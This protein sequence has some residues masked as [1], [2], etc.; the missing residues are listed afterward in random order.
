[1]AEV[2]RI[3][4]RR[5]TVTLKQIADRVG[6]SSATVSRVLN[7]DNTLSVGE[8]TRQTIIET[9]EAMNYAPPRRR[10]KSAE[11]K[12]RVALLHFLRPQEELVDP[13]YVA[14]RLGIEAR[15]AALHQEP[16]KLYQTDELPEASVLKGV[17]GL[18]AIGFHSQEMI[19]WILRHNRNVVFAD[20]RP[21]DD[22][23]DCVDSDLE[24]A[25]VKLLDALDGLGYRRIA[26]AGWNSR[27]VPGAGEPAEFRVRAYERWMRAR[28]RFDPRLMETGN[29]TEESGHRLAQRLLALDDRPDLIVTGNDNMAVGAYRAIGSAGLRIPDDIAVAS[30]NDISTARFMSPPLTTVRLP[31]EAIGETAVDL[32]M[33]RI[34]GRRDLG[35]Q[36]RLETKIVWRRSTRKPGADSSQSRD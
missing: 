30:F 6:V 20:F 29:N 14:L 27:H 5:P 28:G 18:I 3:P 22:S 19:D 33:E 10:R 13:Y 16:A 31:A 1:M 26:V 35:K 24:A 2:T 25:T 12:G 21:D 17:P 32:L 9:A 7:F 15:C 11:P 4:A 8:A 23:V 36:V 34:S